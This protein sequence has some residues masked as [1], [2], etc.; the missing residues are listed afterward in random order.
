MVVSL[1]P[2]FTN[3]DIA[4]NKKLENFIH[5]LHIEILG[6]GLREEGDL[7]NI[8]N[9]LLP[10]FLL[11]YYRQGT[12]KLTHNGK[13][14]QLNPDSF[15]I[16]EPFE[17]FSG[18]RLSPDP[19]VYHYI[20]FDIA[21]ISARSIFKK[22]AFRSGDEI[23]RN[24]WY[25]TI[26]A[27]LE[28]ACNSDQGDEQNHLFILQMALR[29]IIAYIMYEQ[30]SKLPESKYLT[31]LKESTLIDQA[32]AYTAQHLAEPININKMVRSIGTSCSSLN[33]IF[34]DVLDVAPGKALTRY[35]IRTSL[36]LLKQGIS[37]KGVAKQLGYSSPFHFS[38][39]FKAVLGKSPTDYMKG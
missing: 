30:T 15:Y 1:G 32:F 34:N 4:P 38:N 27:T 3:K 21:P 28:D 8:D 24:K 31:N 14:T 9:F 29:G 25:S 13:E 11:V 10:G 22:Y 23:Y 17:L 19:I 16:F 26:G 18:E 5:N 2:V 33:R 12:V 6:H 36:E 20:Y 35:K 7:Q 39:T 37:V